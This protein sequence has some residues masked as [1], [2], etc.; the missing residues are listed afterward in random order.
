M[1]S[2][3]D[4]EQVTCVIATNL[5][6]SMEICK[7]NQ[8]QSQRP[9]GTCNHLHSS[10]LRCRKSFWEAPKVYDQIVTIQLTAFLLANEVSS[11]TSGSIYHAQQ[12]NEQTPHTLRYCRSFYCYPNLTF[13]L[14]PTPYPTV[15]LTV[16]LIIITLSV[17]TYLLYPLLTTSNNITIVWLFATLASTLT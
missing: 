6:F 8:N 12:Y 15:T 9:R 16:I 11:I 2:H 1:E 13:T 4:L 7:S 5:C 3:S 17:F 14:R 10:L